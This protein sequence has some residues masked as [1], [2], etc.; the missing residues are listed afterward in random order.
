MADSI[1][2]NG[3]IATDP[4]HVVTSEGL[5]VT[6]FRLASSQRYF[7]RKRGA[8]IEGE[9]NWYTVSTFRQLAAHSV[10][11]LHKG[12]RVL[13]RGRVRVRTWT[14]GERSGRSIEIEADA[15]GHDLLWGT[16]V[17]TRDVRPAGAEVA[18]AEVAVATDGGGSAG[19][20][21]S[22]RTAAD[23]LADRDAF[24]PVF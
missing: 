8:F 4:R 21:T 3:T 23:V 11:S 16:S 13:V 17:Y 20:P 14:D 1:T 19:D 15:L 10:V 7:D 12:E 5:E 6:S 2:V 18:P 9:T 24:A 22:P